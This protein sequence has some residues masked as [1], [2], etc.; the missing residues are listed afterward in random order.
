MTENKMPNHYT[1]LSVLVP[2]Y[3]GERYLENKI[4]SLIRN[5]GGIAKI[6]VLISINL[7]K[8]ETEI[9]F[10]KYE[11]TLPSNFKFWKQNRLIDGL[12]H[13]KFLLD[14]A[15]G[16][17]VYFTA[18]DDISILNFDIVKIL[19]CSKDAY[20]VFGQWNYD[21]AIH[22]NEFVSINLS[23]STETRIK[24]VIKQ[25]RV[26]HGIFYSIVRKNIWLDFFNNFRLNIIGM[27][28][29]FNIYLVSQGKCRYMPDFITQFAVNGLSRN[30]NAF[31]MQDNSRISRMIPYFNLIKQLFAIKFKNKR[32]KV[33]VRLLVF[34]FNLIK[35]NFHRKIFSNKF[36]YSLYRKVVNK[37]EF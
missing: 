8:D 9:K 18:V 12:E 2:I 31:E 13:F 6:E 10:R 15:R 21:D 29:L 37:Y 7:S 14:N 4:E 1:L 17:W 16:E 5:F 36:L 32:I 27:D 25:I 22:G 34:S 20:N 23:G 3:N 35:G 24:N 26:S 33:K 28:W 19:E 11:D 30:P